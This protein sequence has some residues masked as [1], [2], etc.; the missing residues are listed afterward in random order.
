GV[1]GCGVISGIYLQ[2][3]P[4]FEAL[5]VLACAD[6]ALDR[7]QARAAE[8]GIPKA[9]TVAEL[10]ADPAIDLVVNLTI[11]A[12]HYDVAKAVITAGKSVYNEKPLAIQRADGHA[13]LALASSNT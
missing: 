1:I 10:L 5:E 2:N 9:C 8:Y 13:L 3:M 12:A 6:I 4:N 7:A 11:P